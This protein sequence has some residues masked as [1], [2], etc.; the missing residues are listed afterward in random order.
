MNKKI[1]STIVKK[2]LGYKKGEYLL[3]VCDD[4]LRTLAKYFYKT[5][6]SLNIK[7]VLI[8]MERRR[9]H[10]QEPPPAIASALKDADLALLLTSMSLSHTMARK[11]A[12]VRFGTR[13]ASLPGITRKILSRS[14]LIDYIALKKETSYFSKVL[15]KGKRIELSTKKGT[16]LVMSIE[17]RN[18]YPDNGL[19]VKKGAF[20]NLPAGEVCIAPQEGTTNGRLV[21][22]GSAPLFGKLNRPVEIMI[23]DGYA[24]NLPFSKLKSLARSLGRCVLNVA[25]IGIGLN[26][27][28]KVTGNTLEDEKAK[29]TAHIAF[30]N[31]KSF[32]GRVYCPCHLDFVFFDPVISVDGARI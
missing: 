1:V 32:G 16:H 19:Y 14:I 18:G 20:G 10:G 8:E 21:V 15:S 29:K 30:G 24:E 6:K 2:C 3:I 28:A 25:E 23:K 31:N 12:C 22:D 13:I 5:A 4:K 17:G 11:Q 7:T 27:K 9:M 26:P